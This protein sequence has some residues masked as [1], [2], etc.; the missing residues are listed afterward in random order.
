METVKVLIAQVGGRNRHCVGAAV[1]CQRLAIH[2]GRDYTLNITNRAAKGTIQEQSGASWAAHGELK[3]NCAF[4]TTWM[5]EAF[6][7][8]PRRTSPDTRELLCPDP[9]TTLQ[10]QS[11]R[12]TMVLET[13]HHHA[14]PALAVQAT[15]PG[16]AAPSGAEACRDKS[17]HVG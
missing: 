12:C 15:Q 4:R 5:V 6:Q 1:D 11:T 9:T 2:R 13:L 10:I 8:M 3:S 17:V 14:T 7:D 16:C